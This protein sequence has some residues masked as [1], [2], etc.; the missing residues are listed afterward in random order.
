MEMDKIEIFEK[1]KV[2]KG[3]AILSLPN[4]FDDF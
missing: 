1:S 4:L 2:E 3:F